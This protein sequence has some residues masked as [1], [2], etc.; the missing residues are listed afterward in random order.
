MSLNQRMDKE[1]VV[2]SHNNVLL[3]GEKQKKNDIMKFADKLEKK[4]HPE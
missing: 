3:S 1:N 4:N 2:H